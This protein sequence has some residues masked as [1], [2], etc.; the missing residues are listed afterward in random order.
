MLGWFLPY[1]NMNQPQVYVCCLSL[2]PS[3]HFL[4]HPTPLGCHRA[5]TLSSLRH[6]ENCHWPSNFTYGNIY[7]SVLFS[8]F[9]SP[10]TSRF[11]STSLFSMSASSLLPCREVHQYHLSRFHTFLMNYL[12]IDPRYYIISSLN[13]SV[14]VSKRLFKRPQNHVTTNEIY[15]NSSVSSNPQSMFKSS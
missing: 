15:N 3:C 11:V 8:K 10:T 6:T 4:P 7:V 2:E 13:T 1:I 14:Y 9:V 12:K 5:P